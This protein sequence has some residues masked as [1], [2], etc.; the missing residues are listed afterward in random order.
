MPRQ[1]HGIQIAWRGS[2]QRQSAY[3]R[4]NAIRADYEIVVPG[5]AVGEP[6]RYA[7][8]VLCEGYDRGAEPAAHIGNTRQ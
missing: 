7:T 3:C 1:L 2:G 8:T 5:R 4:T 6:D